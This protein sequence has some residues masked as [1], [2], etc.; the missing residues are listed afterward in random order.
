VYRSLKKEQGFAMPAIRA[1]FDGGRRT[2]GIEN[3]DAQAAE[4]VA[5]YREQVLVALAARRAVR[6]PV[7][8]GRRMG[9]AIMN[10]R[11]EGSIAVLALVV[12]VLSLL[13]MAIA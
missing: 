12:V 1:I 9:E 8:V 7:R 10:D 13:Y 5:R 6:K 2:A 4:S 3:A 11:S